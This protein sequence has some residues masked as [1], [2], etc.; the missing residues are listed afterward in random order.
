MKKV[1][2]AIRDFH[3]RVT[4]IERVTDVLKSVMSMAPESDLYSAIWAL[5][6]GYKDAIGDAYNIDGWLEWWWLECNLG[7]NPMQAA[8]AGEELRT[9]ATVDDLV[10]L[11]L[12]DLAQSGN[13]K[14]S[15]PEAA[16][17][18]EGRA[19]LPGSAA[20]DSEEG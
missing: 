16:L 13:V 18:P 11:I 15:G 4:E 19:R 12:D 3:D 8:V 1:E 5:I 14:V 9:I 2:Q 10:R 6:G 17:S 7:S 20:C